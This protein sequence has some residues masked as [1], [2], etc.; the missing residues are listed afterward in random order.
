M[1][2]D[3][4]SPISAVDPNV[5]NN[6]H[7]I[8]KRMF[9]GMMFDAKG[10]QFTYVTDLHS[11]GLGDMTTNNLRMLVWPSPM[12]EN[13]LIGGVLGAD[14]LR[15]YDVDLDFGAHKLS[16][17]SP[18]HCPGKVVYWTNDAVAVVPMHVVNTGH[19]VVPVSLDGHQLD[20]I[21]DTGASTSILDAAVAHATFG[22]TPNSPDMTRVGDMDGAVQTGM[23]KHTFKSLGLEGLTMGNPTLYMWD[24]LTN[25]SMT[26]GAHTGSRLSFANESGGN[27]G[28]IL[29]LTE[30]RHLHLY[31]AYQEQRLYVTPAGASAVAAAGVPA[32]PVSAGL[33]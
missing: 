10:E 16:L 2:I 21:L 5:A 20:A 6:L 27:T 24:S 18:D 1:G 11:L 33:H 32:A 28:L 26:Q 3:T 25:Y 19:I 29:G 30:L 23:Y 15:H 13:G 4:G 22:L 12:S 9:Q 31:I 8:Q 14:L 7:L 17:F